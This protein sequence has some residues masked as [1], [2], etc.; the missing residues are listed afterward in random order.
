MS[1]THGQCNTRPTVTFPAYAST[2]FILL[3]DS[4]LPRILILYHQHLNSL[5]LTLCIGPGSYPG[6]YADQASEHVLYHCCYFLFNGWTF[7]LITGTRHYFSSANLLPS[8]G[9][10]LTHFTALAM[11]V[12]YLSGF[13]LEHYIHSVLYILGTIKRVCYTSVQ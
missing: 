4:W 13:Y 6:Q 2:K 10:L 1:V 8:A 9:E 11:L 12:F 3:G 5:D 7:T